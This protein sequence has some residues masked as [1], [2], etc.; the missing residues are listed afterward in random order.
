MTVEEMKTQLADTST[1]VARDIHN[2]SAQ[3]DDLRT[4]RHALKREY[5][6]QQGALAALGMLDKDETIADGA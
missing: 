5:D 2:L 1:L 4:Q 6:R 3:I